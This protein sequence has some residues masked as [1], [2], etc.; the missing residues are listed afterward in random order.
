VVDATTIT[1]VVPASAF[2]GLVDIV[3]TTPDA[4]VSTAPNAFTYYTTA[5]A[6]VLNSLTP[7]SG[8]VLLSWTAPTTDGYSAIS[9]YKIEYS[10]D[11]DSGSGTGTWIVGTADTGSTSTT[12][13][14]AVGGATYSFRVSAINLAG[15]S[16]PSNVLSAAAVYMTLNVDSPTATIGITPSPSGQLSSKKQTL[17]FETNDANGVKLYIST[18]E[19]HSNLT[20]T[21]GS[22]ANIAT[23]SGSMAS[24][25]TLA[26]NTW[27]FALASTSTNITN[28]FDATYT[29]E[30]NNSA[31]TSKY[32]GVPNQ[33]QPAL[34]IKNTTTPNVG[35][36]NT[37]EVFYGANI[38]NSIPSGDYKAVVVYTLV[39]GS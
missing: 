7:S 4:Q 26:P 36:P 21:L 29:E 17:S 15:T 12:Y 1:A 33:S 27:G 23:T 19:N 11:Y 38:D 25:T 3:L 16:V 18:D 13:T 22:S 30:L 37:T 20:H 5:S 28:G 8:N 39:G 14:Q 34:L 6:P 9:G 31:S 32:A 2:A 35:S 24:P 10:T